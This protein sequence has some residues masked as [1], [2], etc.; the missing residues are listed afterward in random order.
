MELVKFR[1]LRLLTDTGR[2]MT[3]RPA[4]E[5]VAAAAIAL[6]GD[7]PARVVDV[8]TGSGAI[9]LAI[10]AALPQVEVFATDISAAAVALARFNVDR[11]GLFGRVTVC[12]GELLEPIPGPVDLIVANLPYLPVADAARHP[13]LTGEPPEAVFAIGDGLD[14]YRRLIS[15]GRQRLTSDGA[16][17]IQLHRDVFTAR[18]DELDTFAAVVAPTAEASLRRAA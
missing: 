17:V 13:D 10:A 11:L 7:R 16:L 12:Q 4:T 2:V 8:G 15:A 18:R 3:P 6:I 14:P 5:K 9:A 1:G